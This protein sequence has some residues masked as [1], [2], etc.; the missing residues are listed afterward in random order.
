MIKSSEAKNVYGVE[1]IV[2]K[3]ADFD[4]L[5][6]PEALVF[7]KFK[8]LLADAAVLDIGVGGGR[9]SKSLI[10]IS[11]AYLGIDVSQ[12]MVDVCANRFNHNDNASFVCVD[13]MEIAQK[14][15]LET[16]D[17]V[18]FSFNGIDCIDFQNRK[19]ALDAVFAVLKKEGYFFFSTHNIKSLSR[20]TRLSLGKNVFKWPERY[21]KF[22]KLNRLYPDLVEKTTKEW[23]SIKDGAE[24][25]LLEVVYVNLESEK[26]RLE[27]IG[28]K[29]IVPFC[30]ETGKQIEMKELKDYS[31]FWVYFLCEK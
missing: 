4:F 6:K 30:F 19:N 13:A 3:Y 7:E 10:P 29:N 17:F 15:G 22:K 23:T 26:R 20:L 2:E 21:R 25:F 1:S 16:F 18:L 24:D 31:D 28:F 27:N 11:K 5:F 9:T 12:A 8:G 14:F